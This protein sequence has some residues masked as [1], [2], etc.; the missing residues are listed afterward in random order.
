MLAGQLGA[1][2]KIT[3]PVTVQF[4]GKGGQLPLKSTNISLAETL[5]KKLPVM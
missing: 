1:K 5:L 4:I 2:L 3:K